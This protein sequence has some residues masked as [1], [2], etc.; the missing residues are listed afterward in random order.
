MGLQ[1]AGAPGLGPWV[2]VPGAD[3]Q[4]QQGPQQ[5]QEQQQN[6][7]F[8][9]VGAAAAAAATTIRLFLLLDGSL[10]ASALPQL[11]LSSAAC[12]RPLHRPRQHCLL[13][14]QCKLRNSP[15]P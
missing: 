2:I 4:L 11:C 1:A 10:H 13:L 14:T 12:L 6:L 9:Q 7:D 5:Q 3:G 8:A 15:N